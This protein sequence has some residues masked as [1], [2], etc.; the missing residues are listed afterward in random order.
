MQKMKRYFISFILILSMLTTG[1]CFENAKADS[2]LD[3]SSVKV[4]E[5]SIS[6]CNPD[7][8]N[9]EICTTE[10]LGIH[11]ISY[12]RPIVNR[13]VGLRRDIK[14]SLAFLFANAQ[15]RL[16]SDFLMAANIMQFPKL[17]FKAVVT[18]YIHNIDG[19]KRIY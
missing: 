15:S 18:G 9:S 13:S 12:V 11:N 17:C 4:P 7:A 19:K 3:T 1:M 16:K 6:S 5:A 14:I 10:M 8:S 2:F